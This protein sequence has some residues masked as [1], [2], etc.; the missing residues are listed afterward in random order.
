MFGWFK[1]KNNDEDKPFDAAMVAE[2]LFDQIEKARDEAKAG[3]IVDEK[4]FNDRLNHMYVAGYLLGYVDTCLE[5]M[6]DDEQEKKE[7]VENIFETMFPGAGFDFIKAKL[8]L[9]KQAEKFDEND[10][11]YAR[12]AAH[13]HS[14]DTGMIDAEDEIATSQEKSSYQPVKLKEFLLLGEH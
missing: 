6:T 5:E 9:R 7:L 12:V 11:N 13:C 10:P 3:G 2:E 4:S 14:F 8:T 1:S